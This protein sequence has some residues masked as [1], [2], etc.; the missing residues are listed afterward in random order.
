MDRV[1][2]YVDED[3]A[4]MAVTAALRARGVDLVTTLEAGRLG[5]SDI[6]IPAQRYS[7]GEKI[8]RLAALIHSTNA[9]SLRDHI[10]FL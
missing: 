8:R 2:L 3:A 4:E 1:W 6:V 10:E 5:S 7:I 9:Q